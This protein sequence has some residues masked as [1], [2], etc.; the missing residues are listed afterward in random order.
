MYQDAFFVPE[1]SQNWAV[2]IT[3]KRAQLQKIGQKFMFTS[4]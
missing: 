1:F 2:I 4:Y 3:L